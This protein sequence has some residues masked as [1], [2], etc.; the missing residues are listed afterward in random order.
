M[1]KELSDDPFFIHKP[2][3]KSLN[4]ITNL[5]DES[6]EDA[7]NYLKNP[8]YN[9]LILIPINDQIVPRKPLIEIL[10]NPDIKK[11]IGEKFDLG[12]YIKELSHDATR[13][14]GRFCY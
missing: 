10:Q 7:K 14:R 3:L 2:K 1:L 11:N 9:T 4:G 8:S 5:M 6:F 12:V 13:C